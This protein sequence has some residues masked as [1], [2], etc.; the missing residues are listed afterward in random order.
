MLAATPPSVP[1]DVRPKPCSPDL[2]SKSG[3]SPGQEAGLA[4]RLSPP[5]ESMRGSAQV[6][7]DRGVVAADGEAGPAVSGMLLAVKVRAAPVLR[8]ARVLRRGAPCSSSN[9]ARRFCAAEAA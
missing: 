9:S 2:L 4:C 8:T 6:L 3:S 7:L 5:Q 1:C